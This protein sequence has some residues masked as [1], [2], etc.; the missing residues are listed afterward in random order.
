MR[1]AAVLTL[2]VLSLMSAPET[3]V[4]FSIEYSCPP[5]C[6]SVTNISP[7]RLS[8][9]NDEARVGD[10]CLESVERYSPYLDLKSV[11]F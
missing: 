9:I 8:T 4:A 2:L 1:W 11:A 5:S 7:T 3:F 6:V 10:S